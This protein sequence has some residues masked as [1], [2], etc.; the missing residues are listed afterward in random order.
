M[1]KQQSIEEVVREI[2]RI[3]EWNQK[4]L[5]DFLKVNKSQV[6]RWLQGA[7]PKFEMQCLIRNTLD[8]LNKAA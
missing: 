3:K 5:A 7:M 8:N 6:T 2:L 1:N 4:E